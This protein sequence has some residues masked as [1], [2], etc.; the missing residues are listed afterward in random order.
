MWVYSFIWSIMETWTQTEMVPGCQ[1]DWI[2][3]HAS[4]WWQWRDKNC[5]L[6][7]YIT[8][9]SGIFNEYLCP[10]AAE[11]LMRDRCFSH[12]LPTGEG[13]QGDVSLHVS[14]LIQSDHLRTWSLLPPRRRQ[15]M[16]QFQCCR[17]V[18]GVSVGPV[19]ANLEGLLEGGGQEG[20]EREEKEQWGG[21]DGRQSDAKLDRKWNQYQS[22]RRK[23]LIKIDCIWLHF[24]NR[25]MLES[26][27]WLHYQPLSTMFLTVSMFPA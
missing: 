8:L 11:A 9:N 22:C 7:E 27:L 19:D 23:V 20:M 6:T 17:L 24:G 2:A 10:Y 1:I 25:H 21:E 15:V 3:S 12:L 5:L 14:L 4:T 16:D 18:D 26:P 13:S